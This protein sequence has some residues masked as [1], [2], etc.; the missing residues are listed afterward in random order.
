M[1][2]QEILLKKINSSVV[3]NSFHDENFVR[4]LIKFQP[5]K[6]L[7][8]NGINNGEKALF[9]F[10]LFGWREMNVVHK[11]YNLK[12]NY[13]SFEDHGIVLP[14]G[15]Q[16]WKHT[17]IIKKV[18]KG[19]LITDIIDFDNSSFVK[20]F[21]IRPIMLFPI[22]IRRLTYRVWFFFINNK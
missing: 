1:F 2:K 7:K 9:K 10:W 13:L 11:N 3:I 21:L 8:W 12:N 5:V 6:I 22:F 17:H 18:D 19:T 20:L 14:F 15:L 16:S 4:F